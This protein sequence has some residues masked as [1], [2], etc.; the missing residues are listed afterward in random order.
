MRLA[1]LRQLRRALR[2]HAWFGERTRKIIRRQFNESKRREFCLEDY[3][4]KIVSWE[5]LAVEAFGLSAVELAALEQRIWLPKPHSEDDGQ[6]ESREVL[7]KTI[8]VVV[9]A[10]R[11]AI[12]VETG[13]ERGYSSATWLV[14]MSRVGAGQLHSIDL[15]RTDVADPKAHTGHLVPPELRDAWNLVFG[16]SRKALPM[17]LERLRTIDIFL[18]DADHAY[19]AQLEEYR[20][21]WPFIRS[22]GFLISDDVDN[23]AFTEFSEETGAVSWLLPRWEFGDAVGV[24]RK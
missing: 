9:A 3:D 20:T 8:G 6:W 11:P 18:H 12:V 1:S 14:N 10:T 13:V 2:D 17:L 19:P 4:D 5:Q 7:L 16:P 23:S 24:L 22:G 21:V 15:P